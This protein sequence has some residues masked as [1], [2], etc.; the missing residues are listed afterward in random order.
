M[1]EKLNSIDEIDVIM[2]QINM[3]QFDSPAMDMEN[4]FDEID[5]VISQIN[6]DGFYAGN[7]VVEAESEA[8]IP[9]ELLQEYQEAMS[10]IP[11]DY[12][13]SMDNELDENV[14]FVNDDADV[15]G[16]D[17]TEVGGDRD[18]ELE[19]DFPIELQQEYEQAMG[20]I[21]PNKSASRYLQAYEVFKKWQASRRTTS[22]DEKVILCY[23]FQASKKYKPSTLWSIYSMLRKTFLWKENVDISK[24][25][26][27]IAFVKT[28][29]DGYVPKKSNTF[30]SEQIQKFMVEAPN[31]SF[32]GIKVKCEEY[33]Q[34]KIIS[35]KSLIFVTGCGC[36]WYYWGFKRR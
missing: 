17:D 9:I 8:D 34:N 6:T 27:L 12:E 19:S 3:K 35:L 20:G 21:L 26:L 4:N 28:K 22:F 2:S 25:S 36:I 18:A 30:S 29:N 33:K 7:V 11:F 5:E 1:S 16:A 31:I 32:L 13:Q 24:M 10:A 23:F 14:V 15:G